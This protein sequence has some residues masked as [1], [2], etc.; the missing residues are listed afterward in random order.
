[1]KAGQKVYVSKR[2]LTKGV[3]ECV[4]DHQTYCGKYVFV[5]GSWGVHRIVGTSVHETREE[6]V[7]AAEKKRAAKIA[8]L[9]KQIA[10][11]EALRIE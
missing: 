9:R 6:A 11:L 3:E 7:R 5:D 1:M 10:K 2:A 4:V 8:S